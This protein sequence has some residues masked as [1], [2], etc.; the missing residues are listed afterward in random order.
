M[1]GSSTSGR[2]AWKVG[3]ILAGRYQITGVLGAGGMG[4]VYKAWD[5]QL[6]REVALKT[7]TS[8]TLIE[9]EV[10]RFQREAQAASQLR[11]MSVI[12]CYD[13]GVLES[14][15]P[16][17]VMEYIN[18][19]TLKNVLKRDGAF[20]A[21][22]VLS[23][24]QRLTD[25][26][27]AIH[28]AG[29]VHRDL[30][31]GNVMLIESDTG[32]S[33]K[34]LDFG[35][36]RRELPLTESSLT[37][38]DAIIGN[39]LYMSP[40]QARGEVVDE[41]SDIYSLGCIAFELLSGVPPFRAGNAL[42]TIKMHTEENLPPLASMLTKEQPCVELLD[43]MLRRALAKS[44]ED[45]YQSAEEFKEEVKRVR[46]IIQGA[47]ST[48]PAPKPV[49]QKARP[50]L[51]IKALSLGVLCILAA[52]I[53]FPYVWNMVLPPVKKSKPREPATLLSS[54]KYSKKSED[55]TVA[56]EEEADK[57]PLPSSGPING[58]S[59]GKVAPRVYQ[60]EASLKRLRREAVSGVKISEIMITK[61]E[62]VPAAD[63]KLLQNFHPTNLWFIS[64]SIDDDGLKALSKFKGLSDLRIYQAKRITPTG[65][66]ALSKLATLTTLVIVD[67]GLDDKSM[68]AIRTY[69]ALRQVNVELNRHVT[70]RGL[71][72]LAKSNTID[73]IAIA[74]CA[75][76]AIPA[77]KVR[78]FERKHELK[79]H[80]DLL[81]NTN[82]KLYEDITETDKL[83]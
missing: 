67:S 6:G 41:R 74:G 25:G 23:I 22:H 42:A 14:G 66:R 10:V 46:A 71:D 9:E 3:D 53:A 45:R 29:I 32:Y 35:I 31:L 16:Y 33:I 78:E 75:C 34:I 61:I 65:M 24:L 36:A 70:A 38:K 54:T 69:P 79:I 51:G 47:D 28:R 57:L 76:S 1:D 49:P 52:A 48:D 13:F 50:R 17:M 58:G 2:A 5:E 18:G 62:N 8:A 12:E 73:Q 15:Q 30:N 21:D 27:T 26:L 72:A 82:D 37:R 7:L 11:H 55:L 59:P 64:A 56:Y 4:K 43:S 39:P 40:E 63:V 83:F 77:S 81:W 80:T 19:V 20:D 60:G 68:E 44:V